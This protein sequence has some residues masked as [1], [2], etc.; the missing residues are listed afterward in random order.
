MDAEKL[1]SLKLDRDKKKEEA[2]KSLDTFENYKYELSKDFCRDY[3][4]F[5]QKYPIEMLN[6]LFCYGSRELRGIQK[7]VS[8]GDWGLLRPEDKDKE[9]KI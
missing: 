5:L 3:V 1:E 8:Q 9:N 4:E 7:C 2:K 6:G